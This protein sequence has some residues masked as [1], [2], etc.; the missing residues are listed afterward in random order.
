MNGQAM[1]G[2]AGEREDRTALDKIMVHLKAF[3]HG[4]WA[5]MNLSRLALFGRNLREIRNSPAKER[6]RTAAVEYQERVHPLI[7][8]IAD[9]L[10]SARIQPNTLRGVRNHSLGLAKVAA[11]L[12][13]EPDPTSE[14]VLERE[15]AIQEHADGL[16]DAFR[17]IREYMLQEFPCEVNDRLRKVLERWQRGHQAIRM[18]L[19]Q[20]LSDQRLLVAMAEPEFDRV[21][22]SLLDWAVAQGEGEIS[23]RVRTNEDRWLLEMRHDGLIIPL[24][25]WHNVFASVPVSAVP[26]M[27]TKYGGDVCVK[28]SEEGSGTTLLVRLRLLRP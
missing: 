28:A 26:E 22:E 3:S 2:S 7:T 13:S 16:L 5:Q 10:E 24:D 17:S 6:L 18:V 12:R 21:L 11:S 23:F 9:Q 8:K 1:I 20:G 4:G 15:V 27:L 25:R 19:P 14:Q